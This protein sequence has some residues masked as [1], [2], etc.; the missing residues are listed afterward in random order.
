MDL[1]AFH[2]GSKIIQIVVRFEKNG[3][4]LGRGGAMAL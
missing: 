2:D 3:I 1:L 4:T